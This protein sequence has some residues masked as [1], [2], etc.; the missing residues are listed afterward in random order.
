MDYKQKLPK[1]VEK[2]LDAYIKRIK[3]IK[4]FQPKTDLKKLDVEKQIKLSLKA[5]GVEAG[6]EYKQL[7]TPEDWGAARGAARDAAW[8]AAWGAARD[9]ARDAAWG[10][11]WGAARGAA[12]GAARGAADVLALN[13]EDYKKKYPNGNFINLIPLWEM[14]LYPIGVVGKKFII[15]IPPCNLDFPE[16]LK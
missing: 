11:A 13:L 10:A 16:N 15:Y 12:W 1:E 9:A 5:F 6:I 14:G 4:W 8:G 2:K 7:K 3:A